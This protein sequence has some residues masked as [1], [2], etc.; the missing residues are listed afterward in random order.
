M[1]K[2]AWITKVASWSGL[3]AAPGRFNFSMGSI[4]LNSRMSVDMV[5]K[6]KVRAADIITIRS[7]Y[8]WGLRFYV[9]EHAILNEGD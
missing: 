2:R 1:A 5:I 4:L 3:K 9:R 6:I 7:P 8:I